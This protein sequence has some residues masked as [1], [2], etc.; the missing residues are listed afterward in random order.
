VTASG[1]G[2]R[3]A[4]RA[5]VSDGAP[6]LDDADEDDHDRDHEKDVD[7]TSH[8]V[9]RDD[10][11]KPQDEKDHEDGPEHVFSSSLVPATRVPRAWEWNG[12]RLHEMYFANL[13]KER[14]NLEKAAGLE[15]QI[16]RDFGSCEAWDLA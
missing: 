14:A 11:E 7:E 9:R 1:R 4:R 13:T 2:E 10:A 8:R 15:A 16:S 3:S 12:M 6:A 5:S